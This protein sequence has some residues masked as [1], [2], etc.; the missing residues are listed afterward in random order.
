V[1]LPRAAIPVRQASPGDT[2]RKI[3]SEARRSVRESLRIEV[4]NIRQALAP[5][6]A[7]AEAWLERHAASPKA[8]Y[9]V[10]L[11]IEELV[12]N[13]IDYG[14]DD[15]AE[16][17]IVIELGLDDATLIMTVIDDGHAFD[18]L[19][20]AAPDPSLAPERRTPGGLGIHMLRKL[21]DSMQYE[22]RDRM[23]RLT[24]T[25]RIV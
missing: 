6:T 7:Q 24:L 19:A 12:T 4:L 3:G 9:L 1:G 10:L 17:T 14:Y 2:L 16:H 21:S 5:A 23:N 15:A 20:A 25:K 13:C 22:R 8:T 11:A 18:P